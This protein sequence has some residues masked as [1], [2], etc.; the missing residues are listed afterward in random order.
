MLVLMNS[1]MM[2]EDGIYTCERITR[3]E[4]INLVKEYYQKGEIRSYIGYSNT[5]DF[6]RRLT[7]ITFAVNRN[8]TH[9]NDGDLVL[10]VKLKYRF[11][12]PDAKIK[13]RQGKIQ[14]KDDDYEFFKVTYSS[15]DRDSET[16]YNILAKNVGRNLHKLRT[17][18]NLSLYRLAKHI[19]IAYNTLAKYESGKGNPT[20]KTL[21]QLA[22]FFNVKIS[23]L[24]D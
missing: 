1:A 8:K 3:Q 24:I 11:K 4:F 7:G 10:V 12:D 2:P 19:G 21:T 14:I 9:L 15:L 16:D 18:R 5:V 22:Q 20:I 17:S 23:E 13:V 6:I